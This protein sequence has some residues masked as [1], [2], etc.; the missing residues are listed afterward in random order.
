MLVLIQPQATAGFNKLV[1]DLLP[2]SPDLVICD[3]IEVT[4]MRVSIDENKPCLQII[5][6]IELDDLGC[7][8]ALLPIL[9]EM[10]QHWSL[11]IKYSVGL[12]MV[13][14]SN[15]WHTKTFSSWLIFILNQWGC[16]FIGHPLIEMIPNLDNL[17]RWETTTGLSRTKL[18]HDFSHRS[19]QRLLTFSYPASPMPRL[20]VLHASSRKTSN[21]Y[22]L[23]QMV[24]EHLTAI[25]ID[26][27][28]VANGTIIDCIGCPYQTC[29]YYGRQ[30]SCFYGGDMI[31]E[32]IPSVEQANAL[33]W[34][35]P[36]YNDAISANLMAVINRLTA[37]YRTH[38][39]NGKLLFSIIVSGNSG[40]DAVARQLI[41]A[42]CI[43][44]GFQLPPHFCLTAI[45][46]DPGS[47]LQAVDI[48]KRA[49]NYAALLKKSMLSNQ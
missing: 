26:E 27:F 28:H 14:S 40:G 35:C 24:K 16:H 30:K 45:A 18:L 2:Y 20:T 23:W 39:F 46:Y 5:F 7:N 41:D 25:D 19:I 38:P 15:E 36:N 3:S 34:L 17:N 6:A 12:L 47:I 37:L 43:N 11:L 29:L 49:A 33:L 9:H 1:N 42:L 21:T 13:K 48:K 22:M 4:P 31:R 44:K 10:K 32:L 8:A